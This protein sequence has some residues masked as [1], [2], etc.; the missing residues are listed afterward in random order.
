M[1]KLSIW[2]VDFGF[3]S[4]AA[5]HACKAP[6]LELARLQTARIHQRCF[7]PLPPHAAGYRR[8]VQRPLRAEKGLQPLPHRPGGRPL[9]RVA[10]VQQFLGDAT[11]LGDSHESEAHAAS[12]VL[13]WRELDGCTRQAVARHHEGGRPSVHPSLFVCFPNRIRV[14][15]YANK[16]S[17]LQDDSDCS[18]AAVLA[19][20]T[21]TLVLLVSVGADVGSMRWAGE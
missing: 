7:C 12:G 5:V 19:M 4:Y 11:R 6:L 10:D 3:A 14:R 13:H 1:Y 21:Q 20:A 8:D 17:C 18:I 15:C 16:I 9:S 2:T